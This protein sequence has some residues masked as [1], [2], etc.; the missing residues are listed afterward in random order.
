[1]DFLSLSKA[2]DSYAKNTDVESTVADLVN[3]IIEN[4]GA[5]KLV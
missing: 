1:M 2:M 3:V 4:S 5:Q